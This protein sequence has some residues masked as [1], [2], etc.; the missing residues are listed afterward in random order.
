MRSTT[1]RASLALVLAAFT[2]AC[3]GSDGSTGPSFADSVSTAEASNFAADAADAASGA[4][5]AL[6]FNEPGFGLAAPQPT[7]Q[8][9]A[10]KSPL[11]L[12]RLG[13]DRA[14]LS[15][16]F[17]L[18]AIARRPDGLQMIAA[19]GCTYTARGLSMGGGGFVDVNQ[20]G[21]PD[22][23]YLKV[24]CVETDSTGGPGNHVTETQV[25][26]Q[27]V[28][29]NF[30][31]LFGYTV[32]I[33]VM[34]RYEDED[35]NYEGGE[36]KM[37][38]TIDVRS[39][40]ANGSSEVD[41]WEGESFEGDVYDWRAGQDDDASFDPNGTI[42]LGNALPDG[43][44]TLNRRDFYT[45]TDAVNLSFT[46]TTPTALVYNAACALADDNPPFTAGVLRG[47][48]NGNSGSA[49]FEV[50]FTSCGNATIDVDGAYDEPVV[51]TAGR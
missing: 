40:S 43:A 3:G 27:S 31:A 48:L 33:R 13:F 10:A 8:R 35:G 24:A 6:N 15:P 29:E 16:K 23:A 2:A 34:G 26:E 4:M 51:V 12:G 37:R 28:K 7:V 14:T 36:I 47:E 45:E 49:S 9:L 32:S 41:Y 18:M 30:A 20:N 19:E 1:L 38:R 17:D 21:I 5:W 39:G 42:T 25:Q 46:V 44:L 11:Q 22:D 50:T